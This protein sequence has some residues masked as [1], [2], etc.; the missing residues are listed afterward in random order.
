M[1]VTALVVKSVEVQIDFEPNEDPEEVKNKIRHEGFMVLCADSVKE[2]DLIIHEASVD[3][4]D[5]PLFTD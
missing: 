4:I 3:D 1:K 2:D 5:M